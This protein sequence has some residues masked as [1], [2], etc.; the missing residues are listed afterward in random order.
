MRKQA[1]SRHRGG[2]PYATIVPARG[3][4]R[5]PLRRQGLRAIAGLRRHYSGLPLKYTGRP[6][7]MS[8]NT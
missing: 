8:P 4:G 3:T 6:A 1:R 5:A 7:A 2:L